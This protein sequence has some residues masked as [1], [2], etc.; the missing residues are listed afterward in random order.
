MAFRHQVWRVYPHQCAFCQ[1]RQGDLLDSAHITPD[2]SLPG[3]P[4]LS[5]GM[6]LCRTHHA[7]FRR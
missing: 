2:S 1:L 3:E 6:S 4:V 5:N 7:A